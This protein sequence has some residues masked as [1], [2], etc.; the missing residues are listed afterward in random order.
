M[1]GTSKRI[2]ASGFSTEPIWLGLKKRR[3]Q[4]RNSKAIFPA[5]PN[6]TGTLQVVEEYCKNFIDTVGKGGGY[7]ML[8]GE[9]V[10]DEGKADTMHTVIDFT[11]K[12]RRLKA[13]ASNHLP[14]NEGTKNPPLVDGFR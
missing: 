13:I 9:M 6:S 2:E 11:K 14:G 7:M 10:L 1:K 12:V 4:D 3:G 5:G 8:T